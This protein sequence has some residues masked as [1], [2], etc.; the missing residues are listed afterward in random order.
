MR[1]TVAVSLPKLVFEKAVN[2]PFPLSKAQNHGITK[3]STSLYAAC[4]GNT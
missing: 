2:V 1:L 3:K 4:R